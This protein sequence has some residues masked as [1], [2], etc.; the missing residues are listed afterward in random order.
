[1]AF[2][3]YTKRTLSSTRIEKSPL[4]VGIH[5]DPKKCRVRRQTYKTE[6]D[7]RAKTAIKDL[8]EEEQGGTTKVLSGARTR[9]RDEFVEVNNRRPQLC[10]RDR[11]RFSWTM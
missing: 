4:G 10:V 11:I 1:M 6:K 3:G 8:T 9:Q 7:F 2:C 5:K